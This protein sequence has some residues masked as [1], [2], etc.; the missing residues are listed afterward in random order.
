MKSLQ[1]LLALIG[2]VTTSLHAQPTGSPVLYQ[3][4]NSVK[5]APGK[6][7]EYSKFLTDTTVK[8]A[9]VRVESGE[10]ASWLLLRSVIPS[11]SEAR[12]D[13]MISTI[14]RGA[15]PPPRNRED[16]AKTLKLAGVAMSA[17]EFYS[18]RDSLSS[19]VTT[20]MW[21]PQVRVGGAQKGHYLY[22]NLMRVRDAAGFDRFEKDVQ[23]PMFIERIKRGEMSGWTYGTKVLPAGTEVPYTAYT[24]DAFP[25]W[26]AAFKQMSPAQEIFAKVHPGKNAQEVMGKLGTL[27]DHLRRELWVVVERFDQPAK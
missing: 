7:Y 4:T 14:Y 13:Y 12:A 20:E 11:G 21:R 10:I 23:Q 16:T 22:L 27:R 18:R 26:E 5:V 25:S 6:G 3:V 19:L 9:R 8:M 1:L 24:V 17:D 15:P 2:F